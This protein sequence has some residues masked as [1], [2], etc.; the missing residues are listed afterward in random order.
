MSVSISNSII[1]K[2]ILYGGSF[3]PIHKGHL[4]VAQHAAKAIKADHIY[5]IP[6]KISPL[7]V[8][9]PIASDDQRVEM[10]ELAIHGY[11][12]CSVSLCDMQ[13]D[14]L[15]YSLDTIKYFKL[16]FANQ[17]IIH[18]LAGADVLDQLDKWYRVDELLNI[19][20]FSI[21]YRAGFPKPDLS[22]Y[23][24]S[25]SEDLIKKLEANVIETPLIDI[26]STEIRKRIQQNTSIKGMVP[27]N[28][29]HYIE[30][31][32]IYRL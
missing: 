32:S 15:S 13:R 22:K 30:S 14:S 5:F 2:V 17:V 6:A 26:S 10:L 21:M 28:V 31:N 1:R 29:L 18:W 19:C 8:N 23:I 4:Q 25:F 12:N 7:K 3:D 20:N 24:E 27:D 16:K 9:A 11:S